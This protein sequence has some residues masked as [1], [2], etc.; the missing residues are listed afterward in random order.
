MVCVMFGNITQSFEY[1]RVGEAVLA[2]VDC[3]KRWDFCFLRNGLTSG[4]V[5]VEHAEGLVADV[6]VVDLDAGEDGLTVFVIERVI[7]STEESEELCDVWVES[8]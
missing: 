5:L 6:A 7:V 8:L 4:E 3:L 2:S 1:G